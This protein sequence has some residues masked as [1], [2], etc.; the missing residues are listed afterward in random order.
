MIKVWTLFIVGFF[1]L[2]HHAFAERNLVPIKVLYRNKLLFSKINKDSFWIIVFEGT[3]KLLSRGNTLLFSLFC[4]LTL[5]DRTVSKDKRLK[6]KDNHC[7]FFVRKMFIMLSEKLLWSKHL[8]NN[9][10][11]ITD[12][13]QLLPPLVLKFWNSEHTYIAR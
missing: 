13:S 10:F 5:M 2:Q 12:D 9:V 11:H 4:M 6:T 3:N 7:L 1:Y 8:K